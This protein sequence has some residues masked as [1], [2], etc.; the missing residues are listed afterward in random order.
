[1]P[2][3]QQLLNLASPQQRLQIVRLAQT[4]ARQAQHFIANAQTSLL[5]RTAAVDTTGQELTMV[6]R[7]GRSDPGA[8]A[9]MGSSRSPTLLR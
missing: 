6:R 4:L 9:C 3:D 2:A 7:Q 8:L 1:M 5:G